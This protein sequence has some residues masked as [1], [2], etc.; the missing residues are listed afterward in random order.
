MTRKMKNKINKTLGIFIATAMIVLISQT[1]Q[2]EEMRITADSYGQSGPIIYGDKIVWWDMRNGE[3]DIY[4]Y[5]LSTNTEKRIQKNSHAQGTLVFYGDKILWEWANDI[6]LYDL[7]T[8]NEKKI[9]IDYSNCPS[10][11]VLYENKIVYAESCPDNDIYLYDLST[12]TETQITTD[13]AYQWFPAI[14]GDK[15]VWED[16]RNGNY[17]IYLYDLSTKTETQITTDISCQRDAA[18]YGDKILWLDCR[19]GEPVGYQCSDCTNWDIYMY[20]LSTNTEKRIT[21]DSYRQVSPIIYGD[22]IV[23][24]DNRSGNYD[25]Y[26]YDL[27]TK[28]ET[29]ITKD[30]SLQTP[31]AIYKDKIVW[32]D[33]RNGN[34]DI[35]M[36]DLGE[37]HLSK[38]PFE[39]CASE[40][41]YLDKSCSIG[42]SCINHE[43]IKLLICGDGTCEGNETCSNCEQDCGLCPEILRAIVNYNTTKKEIE[44][45]VDQLKKEGIG[46][47]II[48]KSLSEAKKE[49]ENKNYELAEEIVSDAKSKTYEAE[50]AYQ[51]LENARNEVNESKEVGCDT[52]KSE[53]KIKDAVDALNKGNYS[54][55]K[56][57]A[58][59]AVY[60]AKKANCG[61]IN[62]RDLKALGAKYDGRIV[63]ISGNIRDIETTEG[64]GYK[65]MVDDGTGIIAVY[66]E[67]SM[68]DIEEKDNVF[69]EGIFSKYN[70]RITADNIEKRGTGGLPWGVFGIGLI[71]L[72]VILILYFKVIRK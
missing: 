15:I 67:E 26:M 50:S 59:E 17:D 24:G 6:Y 34:Y 27:S 25:I 31:S 11:P 30:F 4:M 14:Y 71:L 58:E 42:Y 62:I 29:Q 1:A 60:L 66:Y 32:A 40:P 8:N 22:K 21:T 41:S 72:V 19:N 54:I 56:Q 7:S 65:V 2:A 68:K 38:C 45:K 43:C 12:K 13:S 53:N 69:V 10:S 37:S 33:K 20:D 51:Y 16:Y 9:P 47:S 44:S 55:A 63:E 49:F 36:Y 48:E 46:T 52:S 70:E 64:M 39:C 28:T 57:Y 5:D 23:W 35:Y 18:I 61:K 3:R